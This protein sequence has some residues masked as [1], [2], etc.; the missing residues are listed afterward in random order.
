MPLRPNIR[1][2]T[3]IGASCHLPPAGGEKSDGLRAI[4]HIRQCSSAQRTAAGRLDG[5]PGEFRAGPPA[6]VRR[7]GP[8]EQVAGVAEQLRQDLGAADHRHEVGVAAPARH[9]VLVQVGG[10]A[11]AGHPALVHARG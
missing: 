10:D 7:P 4:D 2:V 8:G 5:R 3:A 9:H 11:G 1:V 6:G